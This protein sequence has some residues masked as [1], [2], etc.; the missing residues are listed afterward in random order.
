MVGVHPEGVQL[1]LVHDIGAGGRARLR[2]GDCG[3]PENDEEEKK[4]LAH[5]RAPFGRGD[6]RATPDLLVVVRRSY[7]GLTGC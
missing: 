5:V 2:A 4:R 1:D 7:G 6:A 3:E